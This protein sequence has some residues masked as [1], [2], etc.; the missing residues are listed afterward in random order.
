MH[1]FLELIR[2]QGNICSVLV[3]VLLTTMSPSC[4]NL[5]KT[6][7]SEIL[8]L[9]ITV[10]APG[11]CP[12]V[13]WHLCFHFDCFGSRS[14]LDFLR[15]TLLGRR[16]LSDP[17]RV[18]LCSG[19]TFAGCWIKGSDKCNSSLCW[20]Q[21]CSLLRLSVGGTPH[22]WGHAA[23]WW[24]APPIV[25][26][27]TGHDIIPVPEYMWNLQNSSSDQNKQH[28]LCCFYNYLNFKDVF[29]FF[30]LEGCDFLNVLVL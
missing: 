2:G 5:N 29:Y 16:T 28:H 3:L 19:E 1:N 17:V 26:A 10:E 20:S 15:G 6:R 8:M 23:Q 13:F 14:E 21:R 9:M 24:C 7:A 18:T 27:E 22:G 11:I 12:L 30:P 4:V 25:K